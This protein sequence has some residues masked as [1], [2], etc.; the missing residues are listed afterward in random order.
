[1][2]IDRIRCKGDSCDDLRAEMP[3]KLGSYGSLVQKKG[4]WVGCFRGKKHGKNTRDD[5]QCNT[6]YPVKRRE[7]TS[8]P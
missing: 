7:K 6:S 5:K 2:V 3:T 8:N 4:H 1:M